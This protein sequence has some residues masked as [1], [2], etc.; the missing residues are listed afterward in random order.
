MNDKDIRKIEST[1]HQLVS[2]YLDKQLDLSNINSKEHI[3]SKFESVKTDLDD[4]IDKKLII[5]K[6]MT[7]QHLNNQIEQL[8]Q[9]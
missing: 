7:D 9:K 3:N 1:T 5:Q 2:T 4:Y 6:T 8:S